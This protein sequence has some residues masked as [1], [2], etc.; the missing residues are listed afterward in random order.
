MI[1]RP[2][3]S[4]MIE[5]H[6]LAQH[7][8]C[9]VRAWRLTELEAWRLADEIRWMQPLPAYST[10]GALVDAMKRGEVRMFGAQVSVRLSD[11][12]C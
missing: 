2:I 12:Q 5:Q 1:I 6:R 11:K 10:S 9:R 4:A 8:R 7:A 3:T